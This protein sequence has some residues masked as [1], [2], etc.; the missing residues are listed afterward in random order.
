MPAGSPIGLV[1][2]TQHRKGEECGTVPDLKF[3]DH[4]VH[5][6]LDDIARH[7]EKPG[8]TYD[9][10]WKTAWARGYQ[11]VL[12]PVHGSDTRYEGYLLVAY[13]LPSGR[14]VIAVDTSERML[15]V[16]D[17]FESLPNPG[18]KVRL[19]AIFA[20]EAEKWIVKTIAAIGCGLS[21]R[22]DTDGQKRVG[23]IGWPDKLRDA[24]ARARK[25]ENGVTN[26][27]NMQ[28]MAIPP[29]EP[30]PPFKDQMMKLDEEMR[31]R[32]SATPLT[33]DEEREKTKL[34]TQEQ[35]NA[36][37][38]K[39]KAKL[40][41]QY[42]LESL[43]FRERSIPELRAEYDK[44]KERNDKLQAEIDRISKLLGENLGNVELGSQAAKMIEKI[45]A[46]ALPIS[47]GDMNP[48]L[49]DPQGHF[50]EIIETIVLLFE[51]ASTQRKVAQ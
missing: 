33:P 15:A 10:L 38:E 19:T 9:A 18:A 3:Q 49:E 31:K 30:E 13:E 41:E 29:V 51:I 7:R 36:F 45:E 6:I 28:R 43:Q 24:L 37:F 2:G 35:A 26:Q 47:V 17:T 23:D 21:L 20:G 16:V 27:L 1:S 11:D 39:R 34:R 25:A 46:A 44:R 32:I 48:V 12:V 4:G 42:R 22:F 14:T 50:K 8:N 5:L 40:A